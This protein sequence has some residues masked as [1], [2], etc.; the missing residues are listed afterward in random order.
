MA[1]LYPVPDIQKLHFGFLSGTRE[2]KCASK[3]GVSPSQ[4]GAKEPV[5]D[6]KIQTT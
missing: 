2:G 4:E 3:V 6:I 1:L 5:M